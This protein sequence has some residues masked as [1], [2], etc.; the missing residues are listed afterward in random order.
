[1]ASPSRPT[2][3]RVT[4]GPPAY[5][6]DPNDPRHVGRHPQGAVLPRI[7]QCT[8]LRGFTMLLIDA[9]GF[10]AQGTKGLG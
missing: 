8:T 10:V 7:G 1:M 4:R 9:G 6:R 3:E 2:R 5:S